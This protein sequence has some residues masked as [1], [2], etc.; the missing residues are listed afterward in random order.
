MIDKLNQ[1][2]YIPKRVP[3]STDILPLFCEVDDF[4]KRFEPEFRK[5]LLEDRS[6]QRIRPSSLCLSEGMTI[7]IYFHLS[8]YCTFKDF[9]TRYVLKPLLSAQAGAD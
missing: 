9:Y 2:T 4:C 6:R 5:H 8:G 1:Q 3:M 7:L